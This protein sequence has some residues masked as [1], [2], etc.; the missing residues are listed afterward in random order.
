MS[1]YLVCFV[2]C[3]F[4]HTSI[5]SG[6]GLPIR[7]FSAPDRLEQTEYALGVAQH[8]LEK[9]T[10]LFHIGYPLPKLDL[11]GIP[12]YESGAT[13]HWGLITFRESTL[14]YNSNSTALAYQEHVAQAITHEISHQWFGNLVTMDWWN[15]LWLNEGMASFLEYEGVLDLEP[16]WDSMTQFLATNVFKVMKQDSELA[17]HPIVA[18][19]VEP[20]EIS[21]VFDD[22]SYSKGSSVTRMLK[23]IIGHDNFYSGISK[24]LNKFQFSN[25]KTDDLWQCLSEA[26][27]SHNVK[28]LMETWIMQDGFP[29]INITAQHTDQGQTI[30]HAQQARFLANPE[31]T[32]D[33]RNSPFGYR[34]VVSLD[35]RTCSGA[36]GTL[37]MDLQDANMTITNARDCW[38]KFN[39]DNGGY[40]IVLYPDE[41]WSSFAQHLTTTPNTEWRLTPSDRAGLLHD[42]FA[43]AGSGKLSY[44]IPL[45]MLSYLQYETHYV[46]WSVAMVKGASY[47]TSMLRKVPEFSVWKKFLIKLLAPAVDRLGYEEKGSSTERL[48]RGFVINLACSSGEKSAISNITTLFRNWLDYGVKPPMNIRMAVHQ[49]G[50]RNAGSDDDW[51]KMWDIYQQET[52]AQEQELLAYGLG[53]VRDPYL[54]SRLLT[55]ARDE[56]GIKRQDFFSIVQIVG[57]NSAATDI[58][59]EWT[60]ENYQLFTDRFTVMDSYFAQMIYEMVKNYNSEFKL[61]EVKDFFDK[62]PDA[63]AGERYRKLAIESIERNIYWMKHFKPVVIDWL[64]KQHF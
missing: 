13:E 55:Y 15:D 48:L 45:D 34:W 35:Y 28:H 42:A 19:I 26:D 51:E 44:E 31:S 47:V 57:L 24:Y 62:Y 18:N 52:S 29:Y 36:N 61:R 54:I 60:R 11:I 50:M 37:Y 63:G 6:S 16:D 20:N 12:E 14:L 33:P 27:G 22:I 53:H 43:L 39:V 64:R 32:A 46:P 9:F 56:V 21:S 38:I 23:A 58:L 40:Y 41:M 3:D 1:T 4:P 25:A 30:L 59:W 8:A 7:V 10:N 49:Y 5:S 17:S 2:V